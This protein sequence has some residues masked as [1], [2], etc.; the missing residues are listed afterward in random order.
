[1]IINCL[2]LEKASRHVVVQLVYPCF[3]SFF[4]GAGGGG[5]V[6][7]DNEFETKENRI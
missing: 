2:E 4:W 6:I 7:Y 1:M 5:M 3:K